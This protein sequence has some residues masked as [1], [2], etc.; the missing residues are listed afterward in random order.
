MNG[1]R[2]PLPVPWWP[3][4]VTDGRSTVP[5]TS[6]PVPL[7]LQPVPDARA[8]APTGAAVLGADPQAT[9]AIVIDPRVA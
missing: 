6:A 1:Y 7:A 8:P 9:R 3:Q 5:V 2:A 4:P